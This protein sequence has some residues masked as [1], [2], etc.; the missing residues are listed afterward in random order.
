MSAAQ[1]TQAQPSG[2]NSQRALI[3]FA[4]LPIVAFLVF[5]LTVAMG[6]PSNRYAMIGLSLVTMMIGL[7]PFIL[8]QARPP[9]RRH[10]LLTVYCL[11]FIAHFAVPV[12]TQY[13]SAVGASDPPGV[14]GGALY[15]ADVVSGQVVALFGLLSL[16]IGYGLLPVRLTDRDIERR[17]ARDWRP[18]II[19]VVAGTMLILGWTIVVSGA[20]GLIPAALGS[21]V[22]NTV[23]SSVVF[24][25]ALLTVA[26]L[27]HRSRVA[28]LMLFIAV[29]ISAALGFFTGSKRSTLIVPAVVVF[30]SMLLGGRLRMRWIAIGAATLALLYPISEVYRASV[31]QG[32][33]LTI[34]DALADPAYTLGVLSDYL[35][36]SETEGYLG[37]GLSSTTARLDAIGI[38]SVIVR[39]TPSPVPFQA[40]R[41]LGLF[42]V[43][44]IPRVFWAGKPEITLG[45][46]ITDTYG[47][48][49]HIS[50]YTGPSFVGDLYLNF[51]MASV[52]V[53][54]LVMGALLR[55]VQTRLLGPHP[56]AIGI[57]AAIIVMA[58][59]IIKQIS[60]AAFVLSATVFAFGPVF[61]VYIAVAI[62]ARKNSPPRIQAWGDQ[63]NSG[64]SDL[65]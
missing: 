56:T 12:F 23:G 33:Q 63:E 27:R 6:Y 19:L 42:F 8:D 28:L 38:V 29:P 26:Y 46:W 36:S 18:E 10:L 5:G 45:Q 49:S 24:G 50:S 31:L 54:M 64:S 22:I 30:T 55:L 58:Q 34:V 1:P 11:L 40:G 35:S 7:V 21:G 16:L 61:A 39:D 9:E 44:F 3:L 57:L 37:T 62:F 17:K 60:S 15:P 51:G 20:L 47:S 41:T 4:A 32:F 53:G 25:N 48:G 43:A 2:G 52:I 13:A 59:L 65:S 14:S